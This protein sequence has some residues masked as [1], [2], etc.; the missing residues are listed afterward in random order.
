MQR[1]TCNICGAVCTAEKLERETPSCDGCGSN[2]RFR[3]I[4]HALSMG[5]FGESIPLRHFPVRREIRGIGLSDPRPIADALA[6]CLDYV[7]TSYHTRPRFDI[8]YPTG[9]CGFDFVIASEVFEHVAPPVQR[10][11]DNL[12]S[13]LKLSL[14]HI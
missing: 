4:V 2:V 1:F 13:I 6:Y 8:K 9:E 5:L 11:F 10:A 14:I 3:W 7:N 12:R